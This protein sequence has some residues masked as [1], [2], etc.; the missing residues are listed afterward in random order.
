MM[1]DATIVYNLLHVSPLW[2]GLYQCWNSLT[3]FGYY[4]SKNK[5]GLVRICIMVTGCSRDH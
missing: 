5:E 1:S 3:L 4:L 2:L